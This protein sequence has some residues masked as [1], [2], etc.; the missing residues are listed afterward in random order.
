VRDEIRQDAAEHKG[1]DQRRF[2][3]RRTSL[4]RR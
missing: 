3:R 2:A 4:P 1:S